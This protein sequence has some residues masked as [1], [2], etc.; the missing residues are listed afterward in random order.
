MQTFVRFG[1]RIP[2]PSTVQILHELMTFSVED[3]LR[4]HCA[5]ADDLPIAV[6]AA[7]SGPLKA[8]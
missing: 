1:R 6:L 5:D 3:G 7:A 2:L 8:P 4:E